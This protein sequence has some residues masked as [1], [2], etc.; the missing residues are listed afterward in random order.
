MKLMYLS[1]RSR[2]DIAFA[3][4]ALACRS[5]DPKESDWNSLLRIARFLNKTREDYLVFKYGGE[6]ETVTRIL[7]TELDHW[8]KRKEIR[9]LKTESKDRSTYIL[10]Y[11]QLFSP[12][13]SDK[14]KTVIRTLKTESEKL[15]ETERNSHSEDR[16]EGP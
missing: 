8:G 11:Y 12:I 14:Y 6:V 10:I 4:S 9:T 13:F 16:V 7:K 3:V 15:G 2:P 5:S 1:T